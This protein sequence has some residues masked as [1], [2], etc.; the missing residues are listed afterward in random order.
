MSAM[1]HAS[2]GGCSTVCRQ[3]PNVIGPARATV[4]TM[5]RP[6]ALPMTAQSFG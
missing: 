2:A 4:S 6:G 3:R 1:I 5:D